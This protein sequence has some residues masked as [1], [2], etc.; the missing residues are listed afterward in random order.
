MF[1][2]NN[3]ENDPYMF[4]K[5]NFMNQNINQ[6]NNT[7]NYFDPKLE[8]IYNGNPNQD[9]LLYQTSQNQSKTNIPNSQ[10][11]TLGNPFEGLDLRLNE[12]HFFGYGSLN[13]NV[14]QQQI[15]IEPQP[16]KIEPQPQNRFSPSFVNHQSPQ[17]RSIL[18]TNIP[19]GINSQTGPLIHYNF[20][21]NDMRSEEEKKSGTSLGISSMNQ[22]FQLHR[23]IYKPNNLSITPE[24]S[25]LIKKDSNIQPLKKIGKKRKRTVNNDDIDE[26]YVPNEQETANKRIKREYDSDSDDEKGKKKKKKTMEYLRLQIVKFIDERIDELGLNRKDPSVRTQVITRM[27]NGLYDKNTIVF[28]KRDFFD[29]LMEPFTKRGKLLTWKGTGVFNV[30]VNGYFVK[31]YKI[32]TYLPISYLQE[33]EKDNLEVQLEIECTNRES[34]SYNFLKVLKEK[35]KRDRQKYENLFSTVLKKQNNFQDVE[36]TKI[37]GIKKDKIVFKEATVNN[38]SVLSVVASF[39]IKSGRFNSCKGKFYTL[40]KNIVHYS[41][42]PGSTERIGK[43]IASSQVIFRRSSNKKKGHE[44]CDVVEQKSKTFHLQSF[45]QV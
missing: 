39:Q 33:Y 25:T 16:I 40:R 14:R 7:A 19:R 23:N 30:S 6:F 24:N 3:N 1:H 44:N 38:T 27:G 5:A 43:I 9:L 15:K 31:K 18:P 13:N 21:I 20:I 8:M 22:Q 29:S 28:R 26:T 17:T 37:N 42:Q 35:R 32:T 4:K 41:E 12:N 11:R 2:Q 36:W 34:S 10:I 45:E